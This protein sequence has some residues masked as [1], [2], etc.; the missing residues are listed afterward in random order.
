MESLQETSDGRD[1][2][3][4]EKDKDES[5]WTHATAIAPGYGDEKGCS[6]DEMISS[7]EAMTGPIG[8]TLGGVIPG[9]SCAVCVICNALFQLSSQEA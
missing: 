8:G 9:R 3:E 1:K 6:E 4:E 7:S 5:T 2:K